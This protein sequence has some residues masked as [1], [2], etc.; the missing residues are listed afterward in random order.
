MANASLLIIAANRRPNGPGT[1]AALH[2][3]MSHD[4]ALEERNFDSTLVLAELARASSI[5]DACRDAAVLF[6][7]D[8]TAWSKAELAMWLVGPY[9]SLTRHASFPPHWTTP[10]RARSLLAEVAD[11]RIEAVVRRAHAEVVETIQ[12]LKTARV[13]VS[14]GQTMLARGYVVRFQDQCGA[15]GWLP[16]N[17]ARRL[18]DRV[19]S[20]VAA[21]L[22]ARPNERPSVT[23]AFARHSDSAIRIDGR[24][25]D[26]LP[27]LPLPRP[28]TAPRRSSQEQA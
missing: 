15:T 26:D 3:S 25:D 4:P 6:L 28:R 16:T 17:H 8:A 24:E 23:Y 21:H 20:L 11:H 1:P 14:F 22:L 19:L 27:T 18:A 9:A 2:L 10:V 7:E 13:A 5:A 12:R